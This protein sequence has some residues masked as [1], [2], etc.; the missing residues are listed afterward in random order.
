MPFDSRRWNM[1]NYRNGVGQ[2][3]GLLNNQNYITISEYCI[4]VSNIVL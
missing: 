2:V 3:S 4:S 1:V